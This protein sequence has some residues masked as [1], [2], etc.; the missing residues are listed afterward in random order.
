M[1]AGHD[2]GKSVQSCLNQILVF[3][4]RIGRRPCFHR[5]S[6]PA[7]HGLAGWA[8]ENPAIDYEVMGFGDEATKF[9]KGGQLLWCRDHTAVWGPSDRLIFVVI[10]K[11]WMV[12]G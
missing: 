12:V 2:F 6:Q 9:R 1:V 4:C 10:I 11:A 8:D 3:W 5:F 7:E